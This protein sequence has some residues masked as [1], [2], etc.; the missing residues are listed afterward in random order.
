MEDA[1]A[2]AYSVLKSEGA[3]MPQAWE[4]VV[5]IFA[6][7]ELIE[8]WGDK[9][10]TVAEDAQVN[11]IEGIQENG[12]E[13]EVLEEGKKV[14][15]LVPSGTLASLNKT[16]VEQLNEALTTVVTA[17]SGK[18]EVVD[19]EKLKEVWKLVYE[20]VKIVTGKV[21]IE[22][23]GDLQS[24]IKRIDRE[25]NKITDDETNQR[26]KLG[27]ESGLVYIQEVDG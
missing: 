5:K 15:V 3:G 12:V 26:Y 14:N 25:V 10:D 6:T 2:E 20:L 17:K 13:L 19:K 9:L 21:D 22:T 1:N 18:I 8:G 4:E 16:G 27:I 7:K 24:Q 23:D 11:V